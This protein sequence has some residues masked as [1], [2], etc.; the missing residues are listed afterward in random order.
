MARIDVTRLGDQV[1]R[2]IEVPDMSSKPKPTQPRP[3]S[4]PPPLFNAPPLLFN[5]TTD[6]LIPIP[7]EELRKLVYPFDTTKHPSLNIPKLTK[8]RNEHKRLIRCDI[9]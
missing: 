3:S 7:P 2:F 4:S 9:S 8:N 6:Y 1:R 5:H